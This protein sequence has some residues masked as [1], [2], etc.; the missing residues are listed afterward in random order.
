[1]KYDNEWWLWWCGGVD[2]R[3]KRRCNGL[4]LYYY[5]IHISLIYYNWADRL[6][7][8][9][10]FTT[11]ATLPMK[12]LLLQLLSKQRTHTHTDVHA[13]FNTDKQTNISKYL[14]YSTNAMD[15]IC[16]LVASI[17]SCVVVVV[18]HSRAHNEFIS[19]VKVVDGK[20]QIFQLALNEVSF[21]LFLSCA[22]AH[23]VLS[24]NLRFFY[25]YYYFY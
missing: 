18:I 14:K 25:Y 23:Q 16:M 24:A 3:E 20:K 8:F 2:K 13:T 11:D 12:T 21:F 5:T 19:W 7:N 6:L 4:S 22:Y 9:C 10:T 1:M 15:I 17:C